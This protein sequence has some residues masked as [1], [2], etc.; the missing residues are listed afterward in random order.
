M[1]VKVTFPEDGSSISL[2]NSREGNIHLELA[3]VSGE[4]MWI[5]TVRTAAKKNI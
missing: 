2:V 3:A 1:K 4:R 5:P